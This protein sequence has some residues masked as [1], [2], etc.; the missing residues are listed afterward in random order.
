MTFSIVAIDG[1]AAGV[2][3]AS[4]FLAVGSV[5]PGARAGVGAVATQ[6]FAKG[7]YIPD[8]LSAL[9]AGEPAD[10][11]LRRLAA[12]DDGAAE[13]QVGVVGSVDQASMTG[14]DCMP[15]A[16]GVTGR[17]GDQAYAI[18]GNVLVGEQVVRDME[19]AWLD[20]V[21]QTLPRRLLA[22]VTAGDRAG[23]DRRGKQSAALYAVRPDAGYDRNGVLADLR[24]DDHAEPVAELARLADLAELYF[25][26]P[27]EVQPLQGALAVEVRTLL[28]DIGVSGGELAG[29]LARWAGEANLETRLTTAGIDARV[30]EQLRASAHGSW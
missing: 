30:L 7:S 27:E 15:W 21:G 13:R 12:L 1:D 24:V 29:D 9:A 5:V 22:A 28:T 18:Q 3:V 20:S 4:R 17:T 8:L 11:A 6:S 2:A 10:V 19:R 25:G 26:E 14:A 23:G 16:G